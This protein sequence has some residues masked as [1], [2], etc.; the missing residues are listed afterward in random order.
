MKI[1]R[2]TRISILL[3]VF[4]ITFWLNGFTQIHRVGGGF[5]FSSGAEFNHGETGNPGMVLKTWF[6]L[7]KAS[8]FHV[9]PSVTAY[10]RYKLETG[11]SILTNLM[12]QGDLDLQYTFFQE[13]SVSAVAFGGGNLTYLNSDFEPVVVTENETIT[14]ES[15]FVAGANLGAGLELKMAPKWDFNITGKYLFC[16]YSQFIIS[17]QGVYYFKTRRRSYSR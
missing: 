8:T 15:D 5:T 6:A 17:V 7:N 10:N 14:D 4:L 13:G 9:V 1:S 16:K 11:F 2:W 3:S 12:F